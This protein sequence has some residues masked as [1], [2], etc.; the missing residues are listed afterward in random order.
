MA[1]ALGQSH[2]ESAFLSESNY[3]ERM[4]EKRCQ[5]SIISWREDSCFP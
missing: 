3:H 2:A 5:L 1:E 4:E